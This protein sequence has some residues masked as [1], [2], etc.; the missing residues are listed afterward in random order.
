VRV[1]A[2]APSTQQSGGQAVQQFR[3]RIVEDLKPS[4]AQKA[5]LEEIFSD[6]RQKFARVRDVQGEGERR[7]QAERIRAET[8]SRIAEILN[9]EQRPAWE[10]LLAESGGRG[11]AASG[12]VY[13]L[14]GGEPKPRDVRLGLTDG[15]TT[16][17][18][19]GE[20]AEG[21]E[22]IIGAGTGGSASQ[23]AGG[24]LP[25]PRFF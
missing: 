12:R 6:A 14:E 8:N 4:D 22:V 2:D 23:P 15:S 24:G 11:Q 25:R 18:V 10:R 9:P 20:L 3:A 19:A 13:V 7:R 5:R 21:T 16:E 1:P 17:L